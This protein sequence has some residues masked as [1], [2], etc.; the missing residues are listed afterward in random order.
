MRILRRTGDARRHESARTDE[1]GQTLVILILWPTLIVA[2]LLLLV[3]TFIVVNAGAEAEVA[4]SAGLRAAWR[5]AASS[6]FLSDPDGPGR[7]DPRAPD[8]HPATADMAAAAEDAVARAAATRTGWRWWTPGATKVQSNWCAPPFSWSLLNPDYEPGSKVR[9]EG[10]D[11]AGWVRV[12]V[13]GAV[14]GPLAALWPNR[15]DRVYAAAVGPAVLTAVPGGAADI[16][17][18]PPDLLDMPPC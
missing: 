6:D 4:A 5:S 8:P 10:R 3:H 14:H 18:V 11:E 1:S 9:P 7:Y 16:D 13:S 15:L 17:E 12:E 2:I